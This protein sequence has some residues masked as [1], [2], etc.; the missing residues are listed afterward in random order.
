MP[1]TFDDIKREELQTTLATQQEYA[2][3]QDQIR[4]TLT[5][6]IKKAGTAGRHNRK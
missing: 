6:L 4:S 3:V 1:T 2:A 5:R